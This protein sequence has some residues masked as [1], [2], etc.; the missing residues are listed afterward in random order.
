MKSKYKKR[1]SWLLPE[2]KNS[3]I[4]D[5]FVTIYDYNLMTDGSLQVLYKTFTG[6]EQTIENQKK[7]IEELK[8]ED[9]QP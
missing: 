4:D 5:M 1:P 2:L 9:K 7:V 6:M 8:R 3:K